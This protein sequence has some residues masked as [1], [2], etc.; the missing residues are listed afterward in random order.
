MSEKRLDKTNPSQAECLRRHA[1]PA[2]QQ[3][4]GR[5]VAPQGRSVLVLTGCAGD[6]VP[7]NERR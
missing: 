3:P 2:G 1:L 4:L 5:H 6:P 7:D